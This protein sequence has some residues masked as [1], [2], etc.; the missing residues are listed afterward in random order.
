VQV[1]I[2]CNSFKIRVPLFWQGNC[3]HVAN[4]TA[5][6]VW[7]AAITGSNDWRQLAEAARDEQDPEQLMQLIEQLTQE[8][9]ERAQILHPQ[10]IE[11][12]S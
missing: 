3:T 6:E 2:C 7:M 5:R 1:N 8:L 11:L 4:E 9:K 12:D 10:P